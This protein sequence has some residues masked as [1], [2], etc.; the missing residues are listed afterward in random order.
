M[1]F[2]I[3]NSN[4]MKW[5]HLRCVSKEREKVEL[6]NAQSSFFSQNPSAPE[7]NWVVGESFDHS[8]FD[9]VQVNGGG[10]NKPG[11]YPSRPQKKNEHWAANN[12]GWKHV[13]RSLWNLFSIF[14]KLLKDKENQVD[15]L[16]VTLVCEN[17]WKVCSCT[18][19]FPR[20][21]LLDV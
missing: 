4:N 16:D 6:K 10:H 13:V 12:F 17:G 15:L 11:F 18:E 9:R 3:F 1:T 5:S 2:F 20:T 7:E 14:W 19:M 21:S 8:P